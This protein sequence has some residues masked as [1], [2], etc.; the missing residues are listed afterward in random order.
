MIY[1]WLVGL[2]GLFVS[3]W[4]GRVDLVNIVG[5]ICLFCWPT[6]SILFEYSWLFL[7]V[8]FG[9]IWF[10]CMDVA[11]CVRVGWFWPVRFEAYYW[12]L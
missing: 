6:G 3:G 2:D 5:S 9:L 8:C 11:G 10:I 4:S 1:F 12:F 7:L